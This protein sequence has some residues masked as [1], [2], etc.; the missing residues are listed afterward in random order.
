MKTL[1][2]THQDS[3]NQK[4]EHQPNPTIAD[5]LRPLRVLL[6]WCFVV[7]S[8]IKTLNAANDPSSGT[9]EQAV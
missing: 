5:T 7:L 2:R 6:L 9:R 3:E 8:H 4:R 1:P